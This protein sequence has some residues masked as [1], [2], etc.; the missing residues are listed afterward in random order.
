MLSLI[1]LV[2]FSRQCSLIYISS[3]G[4][5]TSSGRYLVFSVA[6]KV[7]NSVFFSQ[8]AEFHVSCHLDVL[9]LLYTKVRIAAIRLSPGPALQEQWSTRDVK[10][11]KCSVVDYCFVPSQRILFLH[12]FSHTVQWG[13][14]CTKCEISCF[15]EGFPNLTYP[16]GFNF[17]CWSS[18][19][20]DGPSLSVISVE[21]R[22][23]QWVL[24]MWPFYLSRRVCRATVPHR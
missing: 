12:F 6:R 8:F 17:V 10:W 9:N 18:E 21:G 24:S 13:R 4:R 20:W 23:C 19:T 2:H 11:P 1:Y 3:L 5:C 7:E 15:S 16:V 14:C 22:F